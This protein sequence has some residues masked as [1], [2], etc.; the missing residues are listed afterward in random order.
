MNIDNYRYLAV[1]L[2]G[3]AFMLMFTA[4]NSLQNMISSLYEQE[5][6]HSLGQIAL[7]GIYT[8]ASLGHFL[9]SYIIQRIG[10]K[11][12]MFLC[13]VMYMLF[14]ATGL[15]VSTCKDR[16][17]TVCTREFVYTVVI[18]GSFVCGIAAS[19][20]WVRMTVCR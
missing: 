19:F 2:L 8:A 5:G 18:S 9:A 12:L 7:F 4:Y 10:Y 11:K 3:I 16:H 14:E 13:S 1:T 6:Y 20:I 15:L 17:T